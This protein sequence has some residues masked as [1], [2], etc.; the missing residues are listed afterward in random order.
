MI[1]TQSKGK[2]FSKTRISCP[3]AFPATR[4]YTPARRL[5]QRPDIY[6]DKYSCKPGDTAHIRI[7]THQLGPQ[8]LVTT[9]G[10]QVYAWSVHR[11]E[12]NS[13]TLTSPSR[14]ARAELLH[15][16]YLRQG[17]A[18]LRRE[19]ERRR[20]GGEGAES[21]RRDR[22]AGVQTQREGHVQHQ[23]PGPAGQ[24]GEHRGRGRA[25]HAIRPDSTQP[26]DKVFYA[27][28]WNHVQ[29]QF[30]TTYWFTGY[31]G[32]LRMRV[33]PPR[34]LEVTGALARP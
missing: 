27:G 31:S 34:G 26:P 12:S 6:L 33:S 29:T 18:T 21:H 5:G 24:A 28:T 14:T 7:I 10:Q 13:N 11:A 25:I 22:S 1:E 20:A 3:F 19:Q 32:R 16:R 30:S 4:Q 8:V 9:E 2:P 15:R 17:P 23:C